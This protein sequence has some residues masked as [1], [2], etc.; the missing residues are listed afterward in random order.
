MIDSL[1]KSI[2]F[3]SSISRTRFDE[4][5]SDLFSITLD[6]VEKAL[7]DAKME[8]S[9]IN[10]IVLVG[11]STRIPKV[12]QLLSDMFSGRDLIK[13]INPDEAVA[14]G[15]AIQAAILSGDRSKQIQVL[16]LLDVAPLSL[17]IKIIGEEMSTVVERNTTIPLIKSETFSTTL[18]NQSAVLFQVDIDY[19]YYTIA[20]M[21]L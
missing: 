19:Y 10:E 5:C 20:N 12:Q 11:G 3:S 7:R 14:Y 9:Q 4:L 21:Y 8:K 18:D 6:L 16:R 13:S 17:G 2:D 15:A 1:F